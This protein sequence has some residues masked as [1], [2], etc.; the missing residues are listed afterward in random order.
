MV[1]AM[2]QLLRMMNV[3]VAA[4]QGGGLT[5]YGPRGQMPAPPDEEA[6]IRA[7]LRTTLCF[8]AI[9][10][11][12]LWAGVVQAS[13]GSRSTIFC[14]EHERLEATCPQSAPRP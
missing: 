11:I 5:H 12:L 3:P 10:T 6:S 8:V 14:A 13:T 1:G 2:P 4:P 7:A 9:V